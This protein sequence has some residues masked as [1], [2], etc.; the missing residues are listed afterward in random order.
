MTTPRKQLHLSAFP[1]TGPLAWRQPGIETEG[2]L[3]FDFHRKVAQTAE[4]ALFDT[5]FIADNV[6]I[7]HWLTGMDAAD[8]IGSTVCFEPFTLLSALSMITE[9]IGLMATASTTYYHPFHVARMLAS[10]DFLS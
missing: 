3:S 1:H 9:H 2:Y 10:L 7:N 8:R 5:L 4:R 6:A